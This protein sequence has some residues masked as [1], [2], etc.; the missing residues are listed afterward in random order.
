M[1]SCLKRPLTDEEAKSIGYERSP[2][3]LKKVRNK[4]GAVLTKKKDHVV[5]AAW[6]AGAE[7]LNTSATPPS[8][9]DAATQLQ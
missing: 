5:Q 2:G 4:I 7:V 6:E 9:N 8:G 3:L 1:G